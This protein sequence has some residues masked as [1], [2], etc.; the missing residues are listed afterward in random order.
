[1]PDSRSVVYLHG[2]VLNLWQQ[3]LDGS[4]PRQLTHFTDG[5]VWTFDVSA[6]GR[7]YVIVG[8][9]TL[10]DVVRISDFR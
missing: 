1:M 10:S 2:G 4:A 9:K 3:P 5:R 6:D 7:D 8:G